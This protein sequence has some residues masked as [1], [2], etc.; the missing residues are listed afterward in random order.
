L[1]G[2]WANEF[3]SVSFDKRDLAQNP[4]L[5]IAQVVLCEEGREFCGHLGVGQSSPN[6]MSE[7]PTGD[8]AVAEVGNAG[9]I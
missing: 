6:T 2:N 5:G 1:A 3:I 7:L 9:N 4:T 8:M